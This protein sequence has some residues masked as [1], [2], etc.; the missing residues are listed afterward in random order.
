MEEQSSKLI[1]GCLIQR[2]RK[3]METIDIAK[4]VSSLMELNTW[5]VIIIVSIFGMLGGLA[6]KLTSPP[7]D[8][9][10]LPGC[11]VGGA[12][13][14]LAILFVFFPSEPVKLIALSLA[15]G[16]GGKA[17]LDALEAR[18]KTAIA[19]AETAKAKED[20]KKAVDAGKEAV[21]YAQKLAE[22]NKQLEKNLIAAKGQ[23]RE[24]IL[25]TLQT[26]LSVELQSFI[27]RS[28]EVIAKD[29]NQLSN[30]LDFLNDAF[31]K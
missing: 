19:Q 10:S 21:S 15:A 1:I 28:P 18:V 14:S 3:K 8:K 22:T 2:R 23:P 5:M 26:P 29:L 6:H 9:I 11:I 16:Y 27:A 13:A 24:T 31:N 7:G 17:V 20:G 25:E 4:L 30:K 12:V